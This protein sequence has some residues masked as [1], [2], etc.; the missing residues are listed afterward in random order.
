MLQVLPNQTWVHSPDAQQSQSTDTG[1]WKSKVHCILQGTKQRKEKEFL[2]EK[3][4][5]IEKL[6]GKSIREVAGVPSNI[7]FVN[8]LPVDNNIGEYGSY[9]V[10]RSFS[11]SCYHQTK[12]CCSAYQPMHYFEAIHNLRPC[13]KCNP[14]TEKLPQWY[15]EY[16][17]LKCDAERYQI[18]SERW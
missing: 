18:D 10:Y 4:A 2:S 11:G 12:G 7:A 17:M 1:L 15:I 16:K 14:S 8:G 5:F 9:T 13:S 6:N 3:T